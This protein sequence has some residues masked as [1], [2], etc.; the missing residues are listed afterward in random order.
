MKNPSLGKLS[1]KGNFISSTNQVQQ[2]LT[3][4]TA[5][6]TVKY[7]VPVSKLSIQIA[8]RRSERPCS[9]LKP[10]ISASVGWEERRR[11]WFSSDPSTAR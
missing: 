7:L 1:L 4:N 8:A 2:T 5:R 9:K 6:V 3:S 10:R 11:G